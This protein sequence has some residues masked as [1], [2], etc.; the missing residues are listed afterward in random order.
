VIAV[1]AACGRLPVGDTREQN[2]NFDLWTRWTV[3]V[4]LYMFSENRSPG[5]SK[6][7]L[8]NEFPAPSRLNA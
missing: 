3:C 4:V 1:T 8:L 5:N 6:D 7:K 2:V